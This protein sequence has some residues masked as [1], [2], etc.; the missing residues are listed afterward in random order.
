ME[1]KENI[2]SQAEDLILR[3]GVKSVTMDDICR[4]L[5]ISKK[6]LYQLVDDKK[7]LIREIISHHIDEEKKA[8]QII[9]NEAANAIDEMLQIAEYVVSVLK[10]MTPYV[11]YDLQKYHHT[12]W[13]LL[14]DF[15]QTFIK[16]IIETNMING[17]NEGFYRSSMNTDII[18][19]FYIGK[20]ML[21]ADE[22]I[23]PSSEY[24]REALFREFIMYH[25][26]GIIS[27]KGVKYLSLKNQIIT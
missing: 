9:Q 26:N 19:K 25:L 10:K 11:M 14:E 13:L 20:S 1:Q 16:E 6:T 15:H 27:E 3:Y 24:N 21:L 5:G 4:K 17:I 22:S 12:S 23:F 7:T 2:I 18:A 8:M